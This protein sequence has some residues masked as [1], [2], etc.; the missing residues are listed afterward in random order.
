MSAPLRDVVAYLN[1]YLRIGEVA[2]ESNAVN[3]LQV[4]NSGE[5]DG[6]VAAVDASQA[7]I[8]GIARPRTLLLVHHG[9]FWDGNVPVTGR[10]YR[11]L[12][13]LIENDTA[14]YSAHNALDLHPEVGNNVVLAERL[15]MGVEG[16]FGTYRGHAIGVWGFVPPAL[17]S[18][19]TLVAELGRAVGNFAPGPK[20]I[21]GGPDRVSRV[22]II[23]GGAGSMIA[24][25]RDAGLDTYIT[26]EGPH[27]TYFDAMEW[28]LNV[29]YA[30]HYATE[31][32]GVQALASHLAE[33]FDLEWEFHD[34]PTGL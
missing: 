23:T 5:V 32:L 20:L 11:R 22:G 2:D 28:G 12:A 16:W 29:I 17:A 24:A 26:G 8:D 33:R 34:H 9:L 7:T 18:R 19:E 13:A 3:G 21:A 6:I 10:R 1:E 4:E 25:A 27:H 15:G 31:T 30:G 14:L